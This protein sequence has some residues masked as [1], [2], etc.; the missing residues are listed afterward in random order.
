ML[1]ALSEWC[2]D[3]VDMKF[4]GVP[5]LVAE[6]LASVH[7]ACNSLASSAS[8]ESDS[9]ATAHTFRVAL[10]KLTSWSHMSP[11]FLASHVKQKGVAR[12]RDAVA[13]GNARKKWQA[14]RIGLNLQ[15]LQKMPTREAELWDLSPWTLSSSHVCRVLQVLQSPESENIGMIRI[16]RFDAG[17]TPDL[18]KKFADSLYKPSGLSSVDPHQVALAEDAIEGMRYRIP[19]I[20]LFFGSEQ[21]PANSCPVPFSKL[22]ESNAVGVVLRVV[23]RLDVNI[24]SADHDAAP[25]GPK[26]AGT[27]A[28]ALSQNVVL[29]ELLASGQAIGDEGACHLAR[30]LQQGSCLQILDLRSNGISEVGVKALAEALGHEGAGLQSLKL[31]QNNITDAGCHHL[32]LMLRDNLS[33]TELSLQRNSIGEDGAVAIGCALYQNTS[34]RTLDLGRNDIGL[35]GAAKV[36]GATRAN[37]SL[38]DINLQDNSLDS[39]AAH[40]IASLLAPLEE[41][42]TERRK[43]VAFD[44]ESRMQLLQ[45]ATIQSNQVRILNLR[46]NLL[47]NAGVSAL[48]RALRSNSSLEGLNLAWND[49]GGEAAQGLAELFG[50]D[51]L[52]PLKELDLRDNMFGEGAVLGFAFLSLANAKQEDASTFIGLAGSTNSPKKRSMLMDHR[53]SI[54]SSVPMAR[55]STNTILRAVHF[56]PALGLKFLNLANNCLD[57]QGLQLLAAAMPFFLCLE[58]LLLYNNIDIGVWRD[59]ASFTENPVLAETGTPIASSLLT[60]APSGAMDG[61]TAFV[62]ALPQSLTRLSLGSCNLADHKVAGVLR[63]LS[64]GRSSL[65]DLDFSDNHVKADGH[66]LETFFSLL[67]TSPNMSLFNLALNAVEDEGAE[68]LVRFISASKSSVVIDVSANKVSAA[69]RE[70]LSSRCKFVGDSTQAPTRLE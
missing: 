65:K 18:M 22:Q 6:L 61:L 8:S 21:F 29:Q 14:A 69:T 48:L 30:A 4:E 58:V 47:G 13:N 60:G 33:L 44:A 62:R 49:L 38:T 37:L 70:V 3:P 46:H 7:A 5:Q 15:N 42:R 57:S 17:V 26:G 32:A 27:L 12:N 11:E 41:Q 23:R 19:H 56:K 63:A 51:S 54:A 64:T 67:R 50:K 25:I 68:Q 28:D 9:L 39:L 35:N 36:V 55:L 59:T 20:R 52:S 31:A 24:R 34:L 2:R 1:L 40:A 43:S 10:N 16:S 66:F 45:S 53:N